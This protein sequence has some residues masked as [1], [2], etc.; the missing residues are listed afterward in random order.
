MLLDDGSVSDNASGEKPSG[1]VEQNPTSETPSLTI[2]NLSEEFRD[3]KVFENLKGK[4]DSEL[5]NEMAKQ[6]HGLQRL[7]GQ[8]IRIPKEDADDAVKAE[9]YDKLMKVDGVIRLPV[10]EA[11]TTDFY[12]KLGMPEEAKGYSTE[13]LELEGSGLQG[14]TLDGFRKIAH[15]AKL[16]DGQFKTVLEAVSGL[17]RQQAEL[18]E[19][20]NTQSTKDAIQQLKAEWAD[21]YDS[22]LEGAKLALQAAKNKFG[23]NV[24]E[25]LVL[26]WALSEAAQNFKE[27]TGL[28]DSVKPK[29]SETADEIRE[30]IKQIRENPAYAKGDKRLRAKQIE[31]Y[32]RLQA[33]S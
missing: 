16:T 14:E 9:F 29:Y 24:N 21:G 18:E 17:T 23:E 11:S 7:D 8:K 22:R 25:K 28:L 12:K 26:T 5:L 19:G 31:L 20:A 6:I 4:G 30:Q 33:S 2:E 1:Q 10:D 3:S 13:G 15:E 32:E 27:D